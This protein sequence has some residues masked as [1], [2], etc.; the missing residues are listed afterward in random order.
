MLGRGILHLQHL[1]RAGGTGG[2][3]GGLA[4]VLYSDQTA[5][6][7]DHLSIRAEGTGHGAAVAADA[8]GVVVDRQIRLRNALLLV[9]LLRREGR[10][11]L[12]VGSPPL[13]AGTLVCAYFI[14]P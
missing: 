11:P 12:D 10:E 4:A 13:P 5:A 6:A 14:A 3:A 9:A 2:R 1:Q 7:L 8:V